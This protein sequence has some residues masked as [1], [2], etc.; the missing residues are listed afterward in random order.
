MTLAVARNFGE[1]IL[2]LSDTMISGKA[3]VRSDII[4]G[5][6]KSIVLN[7]SV[8]VSYSG[9]PAEY[10]LKV[11]REARNQLERG[12]DL[13]VILE[14]FKHVSSD[15][16]LDFIVA[17]HR[18]HAM[19]YRIGEGEIA[20]GLDRYWI[21]DEAVA[22][23]VHSLMDKQPRAP[24]NQLPDFIHEEEGPLVF[25]FS[26]LIRE[27]RSPV[28]GG[29]AI[30]CLGSSYGHCYMDTAGVISW[31][32]GTLPM[33][34]EDE[35][36]H[37]QLARTGTVSFRWNVIAPEARGVAIIGAFFEDGDL[38][39]IYSPLERDE[40]KKYHPITREDLTA[41]V[42][43]RAEANLGNSR[44]NPKLRF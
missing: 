32:T 5:Q 27:T 12:A 24:A 4:P 44:S 26:T 40:A 34:P 38:G 39:F 28:V 18:P 13:D 35:E 30:N 31:D 19:L 33:T 11:I 14:E 10:A 43:E 6:L 37:R 9:T 3:L 23:E 29:L 36:I 21:G 2:M 15:G 17:A 20:C 7:A 41:K 42:K 22:R 16:N 8:S 25:A 1:R